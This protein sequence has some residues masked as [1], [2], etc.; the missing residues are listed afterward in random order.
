[1]KTKMKVEAIEASG[2]SNAASDGRTSGDRFDRLKVLT[3]LSLPLCDFRVFDCGD[4]LR[5]LRSLVSLV[6]ILG[7]VRS[8]LQRGRAERDPPVDGRAALEEGIVADKHVRPLPAIARAL[9]F[10]TQIKDKTTRCVSQQIVQSCPS[11]S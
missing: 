11:R 1:M 4:L 3:N 6:D 10:A 5:P 8:A 7:L 9:F 2:M